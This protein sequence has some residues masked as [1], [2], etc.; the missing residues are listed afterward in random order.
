MW[1][2]H[3]FAENKGWTPQQ[4]DELTLDQQFWL[5]VIHNAGKL[6]SASLS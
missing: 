3:W 4:V 6:A 1:L 5:P 2:Y